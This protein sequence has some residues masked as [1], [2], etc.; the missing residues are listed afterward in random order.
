LI[1]YLK[2]VRHN[3]L[4]RRVFIR[5]FAPYHGLN[6][7][8]IGYIVHQL[9][10][11]T[12]IRPKGRGATHLY[13]HSLATKMINHGA[14]LTEIGQVLRHR[15][16]NTTAIYAKVDFNALRGISRTWPT[17]GLL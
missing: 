5:M 4:S 17:G 12:G 16:Q 8:T 9:F 15:S 6:R 13:R 14:S 3:G 1:R 7:N 2:E 10:I 11:K